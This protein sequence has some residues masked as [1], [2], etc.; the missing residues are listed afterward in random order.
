MYD[1]GAVRPKYGVISD[2]N[3][4]YSVQATSALVIFGEGTRAWMHGHGVI[5]GVVKTTQFMDSSQKQKCHSNRTPASIEL[6]TPKDADRT[7]SNDD[8][9]SSTDENCARLAY[10][11]TK[12]IYLD[13]QAFL[14]HSLQP[15]ENV[16]ARRLLP[17]SKKMLNGPF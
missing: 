11:V 15:A 17:R 8:E 9:G 16:E 6:Q 3:I 4:R 12:S 13:A 1:V 5:L 10:G 14:R 2:G 7:V